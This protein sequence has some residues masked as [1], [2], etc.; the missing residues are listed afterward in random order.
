MSQLSITPQPFVL[1]GH[2][3]PGS[4]LLWQWQYAASGIAA[5]GTLTS[6]STLDTTGHFLI[7][8]ITGSRNGDPV[9]ALAPPG[10]AIPGNE[11]FPVDDLIGPHGTLTGNGFGYETASGNFANPFF[12]DF[13]HP[14]TFRE[15]VSEPAF[16]EVSI[17]FQAHVVPGVTLATAAPAAPVDALRLVVIDAPRSGFLA[18]DGTTVQYVPSDKEP[19]DPLTFSFELRDQTG[20]TTPVVSVIAAGDGPHTLTGAASGYTDISLGK[21][22]NTIALSGSNN[23]V[24]LGSGVDTVHGG[25]DDTISLA[26][27]TSLAIYGKDEMVFIGKGNVRID[28]QSI[29]LTVS[30]GPTVQHAVISR[31]A[32]DRDVID[33]TGG[34]GGFTDTTSV[35]SALQSDGHG[36][37][38]LSFGNG[39]VLD[40]AGVSP[41]Q[42]HAA[43]FRFG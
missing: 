2:P 23:A 20:S 43:N 34:V 32:V 36:G 12:A 4:T 24:T 21:G 19:R 7:S 1:A 39:G 16:S 42:L 41:E 40:F 11:G 33:L 6:S 27:N 14:H 15:V 38:R 18:L 3:P 9:V 28:D 17:Q 37:T 29:G 13:L 31:F 22:D 25:T 10:Q 5:S 30:I 26:G 35:L 8:G